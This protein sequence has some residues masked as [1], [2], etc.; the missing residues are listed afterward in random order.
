MKAYAFITAAAVVIIPLSV[1]GSQSLMALSLILGMFL[2]IRRPGQPLTTGLPLAERLPALNWFSVTGWSLFAWLLIVYG[3]RSAQYYL[4]DHP[5]Y[6]PSPYHNELTD[7]FLFLFGFLAFRHLL[8]SFVD[9]GSGPP[10]ETGMPIA[11]TEQILKGITLTLSVFAVITV[12]TG[13]MAVFSEVRLS[14]LFTGHGADFHAGNRPQFLFRQMGD[15]SLFRPIGFMNTR[16]SY[17]GILLFSQVILVHNFLESLRFGN[18]SSSRETGLLERR[19]GPLLSTLFWAVLSGLGLVVSLMNG[20]R[21]GQI[22][23]LLALGLLLSYRFLAWRLHSKARR[24]AGSDGSPGINLNDGSIHRSASK[25]D[26]SGDTQ[27]SLP[28]QNT[29]EQTITAHL[30]QGTG[31]RKI[32]VL[33]GLLLI[34]GTSWL[35]LHMLQSGTH[36]HTDFMRPLIWHGSFSIFLE[37][38]LLGIGPGN[39]TDWFHEWARSFYAEH[40]R[41]MYFLEITPD[42]HAHNDLLHLMVLGGVPAGLLFFGL[43]FHAVRSLLE[44]MRNGIVSRGASEI[45]EARGTIQASNLLNL[46]VAIRTSLPGFLVAGL[47]QCYFQDDEVVVVFWVFLFAAEALKKLQRLS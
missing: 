46:E 20:S 23:I 5:L 6:N 32:L 14:K 21:S 4:F 30:A 17:A 2:W 8:H 44:A 13:G 39:F 33:L 16:L 38:P 22:G 40:P 18:R 10:R 9:K 27:Q 12:I 26:A 43:I 37:H 45:R 28:K 3:I 19:P 25:Q 47:S 41:T 35:Y 7:F 34:A 31:K 29:I 36:R 11:K 1:T 24:I 15:L 42:S